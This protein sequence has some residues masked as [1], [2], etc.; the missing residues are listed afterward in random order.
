MR[1]S[2]EGMEMGN[3]GLLMECKTLFQCE[4]MTSHGYFRGHVVS[5]LLWH[6]YGL[7]IVRLSIFSRVIKN[8]GHTHT[9]I[10]TKVIEGPVIQ[11]VAS[12]ARLINAERQNA[13]ID[14]KNN[15]F[16]QFLERYQWK[17]FY[18]LEKSIK[19]TCGPVADI[20]VPCFQY[21]PV[22][23]TSLNIQQAADGSK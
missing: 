5:P 20:P 15:R 13:S 19:I 12:N 1:H 11:D 8:L 4:M 2:W 10:H 23:Y 7:R 16:S 9:H 6:Y 14:D 22:P 21:W 3:V 18:W 17:Q